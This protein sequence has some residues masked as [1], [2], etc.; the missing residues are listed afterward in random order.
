MFLRAIALGFAS[1]T[2]ACTGAARAD[3]SHCWQTVYAA[4]QHSAA[5]PRPAFTSYAEDGSILLDGALLEQQLIDVTY[6][7][8]GIA[9]VDDRWSPPV[10]SNRLEPGPPLLGPYGASRKGWISLEGVDLPYPTIADVRAHPS[11]VCSMTAN[12]PYAGVNAVHIQFPGAST[13][14]ASLKDIWLNPATN[15]IMKLTVSG[16]LNVRANEDDRETHFANFQIELQQINGYS[17]VRHV[18]WK[19]DLHVYAQVAT[20]FGEYYFTGYHFSQMSPNAL[21]ATQ[22]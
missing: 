18:T 15:D 17:V 19:Y 10:I 2:L 16:Q 6:R 13:T 12:V 7:R 4:L 3:S 8:D 20:Y 1:C 5:A 21:L 22:K 9:L 11:M 14:R